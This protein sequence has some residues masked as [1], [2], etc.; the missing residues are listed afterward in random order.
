M[1]INPTRFTLDR[2][3]SFEY[4]ELISTRIRDISKGSTVNVDFDELVIPIEEYDSKLSK[5]N[6][7]II[8]EGDKFHIV[9]DST[10]G[11]AIIELNKGRSPYLLVRPIKE[12]D[13]TIYAEIVN[14]ND[15]IRQI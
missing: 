12:K 2:L 6:K 5:E 4:A 15:C 9:E 14:P 10:Y 8:L 3:T 7:E 11:I 1:V 13:G